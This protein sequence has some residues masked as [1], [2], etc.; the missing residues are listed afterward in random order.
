MDCTLPACS[1]TCGGGTQSCTRTCQNGVFGQVGCAS[2]D[3][4]KTQQCNQ[5]Q[6]RKLY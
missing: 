3:Q 4:V 2:N 1:V 5:Q 6:C